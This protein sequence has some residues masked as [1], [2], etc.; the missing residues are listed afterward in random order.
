VDT[1]VVAFFLIE[2]LIK[3]LAMGF[4][5]C[6]GSYVQNKWNTFDVFINVGE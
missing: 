1:L 3:I 5:D 6:P 2:M 4:L